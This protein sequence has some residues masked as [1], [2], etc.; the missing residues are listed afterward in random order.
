MIKY[1]IETIE[2][3]AK[4]IFYIITIIVLYQV[5]KAILGGTWKI[6]DLILALVILNLTVTFTLLTS[7]YNLKSKI[8]GHIEWH[9]GY[10][11]GRNKKVLN[12]N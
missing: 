9:K 8:D 10:D 1:I 4:I 7:I 3:I 5:T 6:E 2:N 12:K 11:Q